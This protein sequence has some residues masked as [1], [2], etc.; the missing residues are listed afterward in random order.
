MI[1]GMWPALIIIFMY[2][3]IIDSAEK[4]GSRRCGEGET[5][6][7]PLYTHG[8]LKKFNQK[9]SGDV[10]TPTQYTWYARIIPVWQHLHKQHVMTHEYPRPGN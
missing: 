9:Q 8:Q 2:L 4:W 10:Y 1:T 7:P 3:R 6:H 5:R